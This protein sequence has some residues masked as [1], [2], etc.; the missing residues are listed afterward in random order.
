[1]NWIAL[2]Q[3]Q[4]VQEIISRSREVPCMIF[5]HSDT[6]SI[7]L[8]A[9]NRLESGWNFEEGDPECYFIEVKADRELT[10]YIAEVFQVHHESPQVLL[11]DKGDCIYDNSHLD[12]CVEELRE[13]LEQKWT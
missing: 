11:V 1:M 2:R 7:S 13:A 12:I 10:Q 4:Q 5:K 9:K 8:I 3:K 6:C